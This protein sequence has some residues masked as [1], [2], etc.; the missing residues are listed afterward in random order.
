[1]YEW[2]KGRFYNCRIKEKLACGPQMMHDIAEARL[3]DMHRGK[4]VFARLGICAQV[5]ASLLRFEFSV[6]SGP[7]YLQQHSLK[8]LADAAAIQ[9]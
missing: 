3:T 2:T 6:K 4:L 9:I 7:R 8:D 1:M 5:M